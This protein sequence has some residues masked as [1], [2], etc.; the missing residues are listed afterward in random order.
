MKTRL[1]VLA[2]VLAVISAHAQ[3]NNS[4][5]PSYKRDLGFNTYFIL[6]G[7]FQSQQAPFSVM[8]KTYTSE[9]TAFRLGFNGSFSSNNPD[10]NVALPNQNYYDNSEAYIELTIGREFQN[11]LGGKW[12]WYYGLDLLPTYSFSNS[13]GYNG[14]QKFSSNKNS[15]YGFGVKPFLG[16][17]YTINPRLYISAE[18][19]AQLMYTISKNLQ[20]NYNPEQTVQDI[21]YTHINFA[22]HPASGVFIFY[23]F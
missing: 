16:I 7:L 20:K 13:V 10:V 11:Q 1:L 3:E 9:M 14:A 8:Y 2:F 17:R 18:A 22:L 12:M 23:R 5:F 21:T 4:E 19:S 6:Q 15:G